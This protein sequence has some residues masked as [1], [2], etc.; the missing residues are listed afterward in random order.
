M[1]DT[2]VPIDPHNGSDHDLATVQKSSQRVP[3]RVAVTAEDAPYDI[4]YH[5]GRVL[6]YAPVRQ[7]QKWGET[8]VLPRVNWGDLFFDLFYVA[9]TYNLSYILVDQPSKEGLLY[10]AGTFLPI[11][12]MW[13]EKMY[14]DARFV[15]EDDL[16]HRCYQI[17]QLVILAT[18]VLHIRPVYIMQDSSKYISMF[19]FTLCL[20]LDKLFVFIRYIEI[21][22]YGV[23]QS[24]VLKMVAKRDIRNHCLSAAFYIAAMIVAA[25]EYYRTDDSYRRLAEEETTTS[26]NETTSEGTNVPIFLCLFGYVGAQLL[27]TLNVVFCFPSGGRH[28]EL[29]VHQRHVSLRH[30]PCS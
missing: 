23:G 30:V 22:F 20:V 13:I 29:Y 14:Y 24:T 11:M 21:Y 25:I 3:R 15:N 12:G 10:A 17:A 8:Q 7:R 9:A 4:S 26:T 5:P 6:L 2:A 18:A 16:Y 27:L 1:A 19:V 28:K